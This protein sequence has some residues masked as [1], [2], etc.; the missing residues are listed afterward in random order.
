MKKLLL[1]AGSVIALSIAAPGMGLAQSASPTPNYQGQPSNY[2]QTNT[3]TPNYQAQSSTYGQPSAGTPS[4]Q[5]QSSTYGQPSTATPT[6][7]GQPSSYGQANTAQPSGQPAYGQAST[8][9]PGSYNQPATSQSMGGGQGDV[10]Q[11][12]EQLK[13]AG[14]YRGRVDGE[15]GP[16]TRRALARFQRQQGLRPTGVPDEQ[17]LSALNGNQPGTGSS[18]AAPGTQPYG[19]GSQGMANPSTNPNLRR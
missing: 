4:Y 10:Q 15:M 19:T 6:Y 14:L 2:N 5:A 13:S 8:G 11:L 12:Q 9:M 17:T 3:G 1:A 7:Q 16:Q 18:T